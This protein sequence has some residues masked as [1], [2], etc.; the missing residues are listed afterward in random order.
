MTTKCPWVMLATMLLNPET[1]GSVEVLQD[2][3]I[4]HANTTP[5][6]TTTIYYI[7]RSIVLQSDDHGK[8]WIKPI[9]MGKQIESQYVAS[10]YKH[11][12]RLDLFLTAKVHVKVEVN[13]VAFFPNWLCVSTD[14]P[15]KHATSTCN[16][17]LP[18]IHSAWQG[19][20]RILV[21]GDLKEECKK[22]KVLQ[23]TGPCH[24]AEKDVPWWCQFHLCHRS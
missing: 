19:Y 7:S 2:R 17:H 11:T 1:E 9:A 18:L 21:K 23:A 16:G 24:S 20:C 15:G 6:G 10:E 13:L 22:L 4:C 8:W 5:K 3:R 12:N 14:T